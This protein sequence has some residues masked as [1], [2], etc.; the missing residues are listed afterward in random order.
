M[1]KFILLVITALIVASVTVPAFAQTPEPLVCEVFKEQAKTARTNYYMG[2]GAAY[3][4]TGQLREAVRSFSCIVEQIDPSYVGAYGSRAVVYTAQR[5]YDKALADYTQAIQLDGQLAPAYNNRGIVYALQGDFD[6]A[7]ADFNQALQ[8][9]SNF[10]TAYTNRG[11][12]SAVKGDYDGAISD[13]EHAISLSGIDK[14]VANLTDPNRANDA[15]TPEYNP[16]DA[17]PYALLGIVYSERALSNYQNYLLL[18]GSNGDQR[19]QSAAGSL[20]ARFNFDL[21]LDDGSWQLAAT[22]IP[23]DQ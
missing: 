13:L 18:T 10:A 15:P 20:Q 21:R 5:E 7:L 12:V 23:G 9:D 6:K 11:V 19:I 22:F 16:A 8:I 4:T 14:V 2:E 1:K 3:F 17:Q